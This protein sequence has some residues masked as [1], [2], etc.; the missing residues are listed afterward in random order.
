MKLGDLITTKY[1]H[2]TVVRGEEVGVIIH[3]E[4]PDAHDPRDTFLKVLYANGRVERSNLN[5][6][7]SYYEV[8][9]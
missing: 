1:P 5:Y 3:M 4:N 6:Y 7:N 8:V 9:K 2:S